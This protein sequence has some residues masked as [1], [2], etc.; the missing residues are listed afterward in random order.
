[1]HMPPPGAAAAA[2]KE[3]RGRGGRTNE[4]GVIRP[5]FLIQ[6]RRVR[7]VYGI[8]KRHPIGDDGVD[9]FWRCIP[10]KGG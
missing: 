1:M 9:I 2:A 4:I 3:E 8:P 5:K 10:V 7:F 6:F